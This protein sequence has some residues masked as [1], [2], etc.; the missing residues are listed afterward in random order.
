MAAKQNSKEI[1]LIAIDVDGTL[2]NSDLQLSSRNE[3]TLK[4]VT[5]MG[6]HVILATGKSRV[7]GLDLIKRINITSPGI[8]LQGLCTYDSD[9]GVIRQQILDPAIARQAITFAE[10]RDFTVIAY[11]SSRILVRK[12]DDRILEGTVRYHES[13]PDAI[14]P[15]QNIV[16]E[17]PLNKLLLIGEP[18]RIKALR[19]QLNA[20]LGGACRLMQAGVPDMLEVLPPGASKG[21]ALKLL[22]NDMGI[23]PEYVMALGDAENDIEMI[24]LAGIGVAMGQASQHVRDCA[25]YVTG[26]NDEDGVAQAVERFVLKTETEVAKPRSEDGAGPRA[27]KAKAPVAETK[28]EES[29]A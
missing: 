20:Q 5:A 19:W 24:E 25:D 6:I 29:K 12:H 3:E 7:A 17:L 11:S 23:A 13:M 1:K 16:G 8:Y 18:A 14:G 21:H 10:D 2:L 22:I 28:S 15:L 26:T 9:G 4:R 27:A